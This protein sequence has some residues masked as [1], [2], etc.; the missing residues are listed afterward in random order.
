MPSS[1]TRA[2]R[3]YG[4]REHNCS[5]QQGNISGSIVRCKS[6]WHTIAV[7]NSTYSGRSTADDLLLVVQICLSMPTTSSALIKT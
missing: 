6:S 7:N 5:P 4:L 1:E 2:Q 3:P